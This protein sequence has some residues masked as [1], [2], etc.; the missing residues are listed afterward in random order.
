M[1]HATAAA[2]VL[3]LL[4]CGPEDLAGFQPQPAAGV[5][6]L[7]HTISVRFEAGAATLKVKRVLRNDTDSVQSYEHH[8]IALPEGGIATALRI[9]RGAELPTACSLSTKEDVSARWDLLTSPGDAAPAPIGRLEWSNDEGLDLDLFGLLP[10]ETVTVEYD[11]QVSPRY[12]AGVLLF[13][14]PHDS[15]TTPRFEGAAVEETVDGFVVRRQHHTDAVADVRWATSQLDTNRTLWRFEVDAAPELSRAPVAPRVVFVI[16]ASHSQRPEGI[17]A[18]LEVI[19]PYLANVPDAQV[20]LVITRRFAER[21]FGRFVPARD[22]AGLLASTPAERL[23]PGNGSNLDVGAALAAQLLAREGGAGRL[24]LFTDE[25]L[26]TGFSNEQTITALGGPNDLVAHVLARADFTWG[27]LAEARDDAAELSPIAAATGGIFARVT[28]EPTDPEAS[29]KALLNL[30]RPVRVDDFKVEAAGLPDLSL[31]EELAEGSMVRVQG[32]DATPPESLTVSGK[33]WAREFHRVVS[34]DT[35]L[36]KRL[37]GIAVGDDDLRAGLSDDELRT[38]A[39]LSHAVSPVTSFMFVSPGAAP[40]TAG[41]TELYGTGALDLRGIGCGGCGVSSHCGF[42]VHGR[43]VDFEALLQHL[44][45][46][47]V[48][49]CEAQTGD[50]AT[51]TVGVEATGDEVVAVT[52]TGATPAMNECLTEAAWAIR[53]SAEFKATRSYSVTLSQDVSPRELR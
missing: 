12:E 28:G 50:A 16:D 33:L 47:G 1:R 49:A 35:A 30:V 10:S 19:G 14:V 27:T 52:V 32:V 48:A 46:A 45:A 17:A 37:P 41:L 9:G 20:E 2:A 11:V 18:Q 5:H 26:R 4:A 15:T 22:V 43:A 44:L 7:S 13:D 21:L 38:A 24:L 34:V 8:D 6:E 39:F 40:S 23:A 53:L 25:K 51:A 36:S 42:G 31:A 3:S 29:A